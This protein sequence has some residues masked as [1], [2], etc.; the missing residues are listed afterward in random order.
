MLKSSAYIRGHKK[1]LLL[2]LPPLLCGRNLSSSSA[3]L[4]ESETF[5]SAID[6]DLWD[7]WHCQFKSA[8]ESR[9]SLIHLSPS[10]IIVTR[11]QDRNNRTWSRSPS[12][13][14][15]RKRRRETGTWKE[16]LSDWLRSRT[17]Q[18]RMW[19]CHSR[20]TELTVEGIGEC[21][22]NG[23]HLPGT[24]L[25]GPSETNTSEEEDYRLSLPLLP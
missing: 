7:H 1:L 17:T 4:L 16:G 18:R 8:T 23:H 11:F 15:D 20:V 22:R 14:T 10:H 21:V 3:E 25:D 6:D 12:V 5:M 13:L 9:L 2:S 19:E 24:N